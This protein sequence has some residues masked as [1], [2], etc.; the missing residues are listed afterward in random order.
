MSTF[1]IRFISG[2]VC[3]VLALV[4]IFAPPLVFHIAVGAACLV[5]LYELYRTFEQTKKWQIMV[6]G[7]LFAV[8][9]LV[10]PLFPI[11]LPKELFMFLLVVYL[12]LLSVCSVVYHETIKFADVT[13]GF[14]SLVY[15]VLLLLHLSYI[16]FLDNGV[17]LVILVFLGAWLPDTF[18][19][20]AGRFFG[21]HKLI[22]AVSPKKTIEGSVGG[23]LG[24]VISF[25]VYGVVL[26]FGFGYTVNYWLL[27][28][29]ALTCGVVSQFGDLSASVIK[30]ECGQKDFGNLIPGHGGI[31]DRFDSLI[32][33]AP[34]IYYFLLIFE[35]I[36]K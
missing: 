34:L 22:P 25:M 10:M 24:A 8:I 9:F 4:L 19:Y 18:A 23:V 6:L 11:S 14:F 33:V 35:V 13:R 15:G 16:R 12:M 2:A 29:L 21:K 20:F 31:L 3:A 5:A 32:F 26:Q 36:Y 30:R 28:F 17:A 1:Q 7:Y 27:L